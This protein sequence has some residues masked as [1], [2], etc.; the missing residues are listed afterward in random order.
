MENDIQ[1]AALAGH[2]L[3]YIRVEDFTP[4]ASPPRD[5]APLTDD[6]G[7]ELPSS[8]DPF[9]GHVIDLIA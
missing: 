3:S 7:D 2:H 4:I 9:R 6:K 8:L 5:T 1:K